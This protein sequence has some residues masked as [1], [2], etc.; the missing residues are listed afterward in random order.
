MTIDK[1]DRYTQA[2]DTIV[3]TGDVVATQGENVAK[4]SRL[5]VH[6][7]AGTSEMVGEPGTGR[8]RTVVYPN[9]K[10]NPGQ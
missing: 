1:P 6:V 8:V 4:G 5:I 7:K 3:V 2:D 9:K 10:Q